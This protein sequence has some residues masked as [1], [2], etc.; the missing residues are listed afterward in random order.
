MTQI[1]WGIG[2][3]TLFDIAADLL[4][5]ANCSFPNATQVADSDFNEWISFKRA[6]CVSE[7][8]EDRSLKAYNKVKSYITDSWIRV[9]EKNIKRFD[10]ENWSHFLCSSNS[11]RALKLEDEDRRWFIVGCVEEL[12]PLD[13]WK[14]FHKWKGNNLGVIAAY[15]KSVIETHGIIET[16][17][18]RPSRQLYGR[19]QRAF[20]ASLKARH[21]A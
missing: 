14:G 3:T 17:M 13:Y 1:T 6:V 10:I 7:L 5:R 2:K 9:N 15:L 20:R 18:A 16:G 21:W 19:I 12:R 11:Y 4:G 8:H